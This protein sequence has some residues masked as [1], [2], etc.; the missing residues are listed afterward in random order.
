MMTKKLTISLLL[1]ILYIFIPKPSHSQEWF[2]NLPESKVQNGTLTLYDYQKAFNEYWE[3]RQVNKGYYI[4]DGVEVKAP[5]WKQFK[6]WEWFWESRVDPQTGAFPKTSSSEEFEKYKIANPRST[7]SPS[8]AWVSL[9][10]TSSSGGYAGIGRLNCIAFHPGDNNTLYAGAPGGGIWKSS[11]GGSS[12]TPIGDHNPVLGVSDIIVIDQGGSPDILYIATGDKDGGSMWSLGGGQSNDNNSV[13]VLKST[14]GGTTWNPT[15]LTFSASTLITI[16]RLILDPTSGNQTIYA[17]TSNGIYKTSDAGTNWT[18]QISG[19]FID[20]EMNPGNN[21]TLYASTIDYYGSPAIYYTTNG[22]TS[23]TASATFLTTDFRIDLAVT[24]DNSAYVYAVVAK[25]DGGLRSIQRSTNSG[26]SFSQMFS[27]TTTNLLNWDCSSSSAGGQGSYDLCIAADPNDA[28]TVFVGGVNTWKSTTGGSSW[29]ISTHWSGTCSGAATTVHADEHFL[30]Y[31]NGTSNLFLCSDG[32]LYKT[33]NGGASWSDLTNTMAI[34]QLYRIGVA[35]TSANEVICGLQDNG[36]KIYSSGSWSDVLGGD[37]M[38]CIIDHTTLNTQY[39][40]LYNGI[41][42]RTLD[43]WGSWTS[44]GPSSGAWVTP[45]AMDPNSN[46]TLIAGYSDVYISTNRGNG[47][48]TISS[49]LTGGVDLR[50][51][52]IAPSSSNTIYVA[53]LNRI[54]RTTNGG[55]GWTEITTG[56]PVT[57][58]SITYISVK[59]NDPNTLWVSFGNYDSEGVYQSTNGGSTWTNISSGLPTL[60]V[61]C[62]IQ[63]K[64]NTSVDELYAGTDVGIYVKNGTANWEPFFTGLPNVVVTELE[65]YYD[66]STPANSRIRAATFGRGLWESDLYEEPP[67]PNADFSADI[68][69]PNLG[70]TVSFTD[71]STN[72]PTS[73]AWSFS[74]TSVTYTGGTNASSQNPQVEFTAAGPYTV[75]LTATNAFGS[76]LESK[77]DYI[78]AIDN[79]PIT[80]PW[81]EDFEPVSPTLTFTA[82]INNIGGIPEWAYEKTDLGRLRFEAGTGFYH[83]GTKAAT[84]DANPSGT[85]SVNYLTATLNLSNYT[86][87]DLLFSFWYMHHGEEESDNDRVWIRGSNTDNWVEVYN[88]YNNQGTASTWNE[89]ADLDIDALLTAAAPSQTVSSTFQIRLGQEDNFPATST[90]GSDG[91]SFDDLIVEVESSGTAPV[92]DFIAN[93]TAGESGQNISF[94]DLSTN[95]PTQWRWNFPGGNPPYSELQNPVI[96]YDNEGYYDVTLSASNASGT[97]YLS[98]A[99]YLSLSSERNSFLDDFESA[100]PAWSLSGEFERATPAGLGGAE[101]DYP[102]PASAYDGS[103][104]IGTDLSG[105]GSNPGDYEASLGSLAYTAISPIINCSGYSNVTL[106]FMRWLNVETSTYDEAFIHVNNGSGWVEIWANSATM[107]ESAWTWVEYDISAIADDEANVQI[108]FGLGPTDDYDQYSGWN[109]DSLVVKGQVLGTEHNVSWTGSSNNNWHNPSN[110]SHGTI[111]GANTNVSIPQFIPGGNVV[112]TFSSPTSEVNDLIIERNAILSIPVGHSMTINGDM[113][114]DE[115]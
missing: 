68:L 96:R 38:E 87:A 108:R 115:D 49:N 16:S 41:I 58:A 50:S 18:Q 80:L 63:N 34:S 114:I 42:R 89:V 13:G 57:S 93:L 32:G 92:V 70:Q 71:L 52:A 44:I 103:Y 59:D 100:S 28:N 102:D 84:L 64:L 23:W 22:G 106:G 2:K 15:G 104:V 101:H 8:G 39:G 78:N 35:Q 53:T 33:T 36:S 76:N 5:Y 111:P 30:A 73:W 110:W 98:K 25:Q 45:F 29:G 1:I 7:K 9:G 19:N 112:N 81:I 113:N 14:D 94:T 82:N 107:P 37:G 105:L 40:S 74:P 11:N 4:K 31:Q 97:D 88:L 109:I 56:L 47:W 86:A 12:W 67:E 79:S 85:I 75:E 46:T 65:I 51:L 69:F 55:G 72:S 6:R 83:D 48:S 66:M 24:S 54:W 60:P 20:M 62:V 17:A 91:Y 26:A 21:N 90:S 99:D 61:M 43:H 77:T 3:P 10:P 95:S 27:G